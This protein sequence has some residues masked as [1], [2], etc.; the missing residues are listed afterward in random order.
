MQIFAGNVESAS[1]AQADADE[2][3]VEILFEL[4]EGDVAADGGLLTKFD[5]QAADELDFA[6]SIFGAEFVGGDAVGVQAA[7]EFIA[8]E[9]CGA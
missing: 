1:I 5:A 3:R 7:G 8:I 2:N 6:Q 4:G 9:N